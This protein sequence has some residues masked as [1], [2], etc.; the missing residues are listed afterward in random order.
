MQFVLKMKKA[1]C[2]ILLTKNIMSQGTLKQIEQVANLALQCF[3]LRGEERADMK[4]I[5]SGN[6]KRKGITS[7]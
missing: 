6:N 3:M 2:G 7:M 1:A 5:A 4:E